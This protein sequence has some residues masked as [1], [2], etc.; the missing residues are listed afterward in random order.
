MGGT[1]YEDTLNKLGKH[2]AKNDWWEAHGITV[3]RTRF[4]GM[5]DVPWSFGDYCADGSNIVI[6]SKQ[7]IGEVSTN[8]GREHRRFADEIRRANAD[9]CLLVVLVETDEAACIEDVSAWVNGH[10]RKCGHY[11]RRDC[12]P[13]DRT[14]ICIKHGTAKPLQGD[15]VAKQMATMERTRCVRFEFVRPDASAKRICE[16]LGVSYD[17]ET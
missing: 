3:V 14:D 11:W 9:G 17:T 6:D 4:D 5:H 8:L 1:I 15:T 2:T 12:D 7:N 13:R 10:C 16:L